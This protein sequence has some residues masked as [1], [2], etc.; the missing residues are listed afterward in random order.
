MAVHAA[1]IDRMD[2]GIGRIIQTLKE[3]GELEN[4]L[5]VFLSDNGASSENCM[6]YG[7]GFDRPGETRDDRKIV[8]PVDTKVLP[9]PQTSPAT[10]G[11]PRANLPNTPFPYSIERP[12]FKERL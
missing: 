3:T 8:Y 2:Q 6:R 1:M 10:I 11:Q 4:T 5:I 9:G 7:P 12:S